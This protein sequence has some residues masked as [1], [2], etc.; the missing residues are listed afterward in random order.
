LL[1]IA[2][3]PPLI[4]HFGEGVGEKGAWRREEIG[5]KLRLG[6]RILPKGAKDI[7]HLG[8][9]KGDKTIWDLDGQTIG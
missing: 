3:S 5:G 9:P 7:S 8:L 6:T 2:E 1:G 4:A